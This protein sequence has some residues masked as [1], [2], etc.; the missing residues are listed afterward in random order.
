MENLRCECGHENPFGTKLCEICGRPLTKEEQEQK[1]ADMRYDGTAIRSKTYNKSIIDKVWNFFSSV[2]VGITL[3]ILNLIAASLGTFLPQEFYIQASTD[4]QKLE[5]YEKMYGTFGRVYYELGLSDA[6]SAWWFQILVGL[7]GVSIIV[8]SIDRGIPLHKSLKNQRVKRHVSFMK[9]QR[10]VSDDSTLQH[11]ADDNTLRLVTEALKKS[12]Y[13]VRQEGNAILGERGRFARYGPYINH[14]GL[15][16]FLLGVMLHVVPGLYT[17]ESM[18]VAEGEILAVP[19]MEGYLIENKQFILETYDN[20]AQGEQ[21]KQGVNVV[22]KNFQTNAVLYKVKDGAVAGQDDEREVVK[23]FEIRVN[24]PLKYDGFAFYQMDYQLNQLKVMKF[25][26]TNKNTGESLGEVSIDL[27]DPQK[28]YV[29]DDKTRVELIDFLPDFSGFNEEGKPQTA[30]PNPNNPAFIFRMF[31][32]SKPEGETSFVA[33]QETLEPLGENEYKMAFAGIETYN[34]TGLAIHNNKTIPILFIGG[35]IFML[36][37]IIG[38]YFSH[39]RIWLE[40]QQD[41]SVRYAAHTNKN[42]MAIKKD[43]D[44][45]VQH[46]K[47]PNYIDRFDLEKEIEEQNGEGDSA[48]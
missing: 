42:W 29:L 31:T 14:L 6:Y 41:G 12:K 25:N 4:A 48:Q 46:A 13:N 30:T 43:L 9:R 22:A 40:V 24:H 26:L 37:L 38:S 1:F 20:E 23:E 28:E 11:K 17:N 32:E 36:G 35:G 34:K 44:M 7:L 15:I 33:I 2:K 5:Y 47:L 21:L 18:W 8:A 10:I 45:I 27:L 39:R 16:I 3:I 19:G